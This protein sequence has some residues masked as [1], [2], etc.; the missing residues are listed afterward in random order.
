M[1]SDA[2]YREHLARSRAAVEEVLAGLAPIDGDEGAD[3]EDG[4]SDGRD[5]GAP[6]PWWRRGA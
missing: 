4:E 6:R 2:V 5:A 3:A 1:A